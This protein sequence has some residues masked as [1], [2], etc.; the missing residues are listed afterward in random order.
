MANR[1]PPW[2]IPAVIDP[3]LRRC[4]QIKIPDHPDHIEIF[5]GVL[6]GLS[7]WQRWER[8]PS[9]SGTL[10]AQVWREVVYAIDWSNMSCCPE[11]T[12]RRYNAEGQ[13]EV[14]YDNGATWVTDP[15]LD[16]RLSGAISPP[17][18][19][20]DGDD[21]KCIAATSAQDFIKANLIDS[22]SEGQTYAEL[23]GA[24]VAII[25]VL[26]VTGVG[27]LLGAAVAAIFLAGVTV[28]QAAFTSEVWTDFRCI[29]YCAIEP[30]GSFSVAGWEEVKSKIL[31][32]FTG[33]VS[34]ILYNWA[35]A[36]GPVGL[37]NAA[38]SHFAA[39]G[40]CSDCD[41]VDH[42]ADPAMFFDGTVNSVTNNG[43]GTTTFN[44]SS[45][46]SI[47]GAAYVAWGSR[48]DPGSPCCTFKGTNLASGFD[49]GSAEQLCGS[50]TE[51]ADTLQIDHCVHYFHIYKNSAVTTPW[52]A[53]IVMGGC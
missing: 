7:D 37:T 25:A 20:A 46:F 27:I 8:E 40:D 26:G 5:W 34:A 18:D 19:G 45:V 6:R 1:R 36:A 21:K 17:L 49:L 39:S 38:R 24:M 16:S 48:T 51:T 50:S 44:V 32:T 15:A 22:L 2:K 23:T 47:D 43:D 52:T 31:T 41:C 11:P 30:D 14:S 12:N 29:L 35:N 4:I 53:D 42:C 9:K 33:A 13:L 3:P 28:I 10:V